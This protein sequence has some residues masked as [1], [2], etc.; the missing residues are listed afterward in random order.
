MNLTSQNRIIPPPIS[1]LLSVQLNGLPFSGMSVHSQE[2]RLI[3]ERQQF[4][5]KN[6][7]TIQSNFFY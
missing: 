7:Q 6:E 2:W 1:S 4:Q 3:P 5:L